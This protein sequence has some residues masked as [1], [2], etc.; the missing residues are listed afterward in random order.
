[1]NA[2]RRDLL[3]FIGCAPLLARWPSL[4]RFAKAPGGAESPKIRDYFPQLSTTLNGHPLAYLDSAATTLRPRPVLDAMRKFYEDQN[5]NPGREVH[6]VAATAADEFDSARARMA[7]FIN[8]ADPLEIIWTRG[9][10]EALNLVASAWGGP[11]LQAGDELI[12]TIA[13]HASSMLPWQIAAAK[14][15]ATIR[16]IEVDEN[17]HLKLRDLETLL[18]KR[19]KLVCFTYVSNVLG[20]IN[21]AKELCHRARGAGARVLIDAAQAVPHLRI[22]V[23]ELGCD[24]AAFSSHKMLGPMGA[25][26]LY[27]RRQAM[28]EM[29]VYQAGSNM[30]HAR[31]LTDWHYSPGALRFGAGTPNVADAVGLASAAELLTTFD[32]GKLW[33]SEQQLTR[34]ALTRLQQVRGL[35][36]LGPLVAEQRI[37]IFS[38]VIAG[39]A[40]S[41]IVRHVDRL[42]ICIRAGD[43]ASMPLLQRFGLESAARASLYVYS[44]EAEIDRLADA[45]EQLESR[46]MC[47]RCA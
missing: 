39:V 44:T 28:E 46:K 11:H 3:Q 22:D 21:P 43:L 37:A 33:S 16:Y 6:S 29:Q 13:E 23:Q 9:T 2:T 45:L 17:G 4:T 35:R 27:A 42:G 30:A 36:I 32:R 10:T 18:S 5:A 31:S 15:R 25:G 14:G 8:A 7:K 40:A 24:F 12:L 20:A 34:Y 47:D 41:T 19:T 38:F 26:V 1:M